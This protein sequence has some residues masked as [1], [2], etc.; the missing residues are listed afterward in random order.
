MTRRP[1]VAVLLANWNGARF[2]DEA[3]TSVVGQSFTDWVL[4]A[5][6]TGSRDDSPAIIKKW[7][8]TDARIQPVLI[9]QRLSYPEALNL[10]LARAQGDYVAR[11]ESD[12][13]WLPERL[14]R[15]IEFYSQADNSSVGVCGTDALLVNEFGRPVRLKQFPRLHV[16]CL[17][18]IWYRNP[19][20]NSSVLIR[21]A[22][23]AEIGGYD[24][25]FYMVEDL[26]LWFRLGRQWSLR[27]IPEALVRYRV[28]PDSTSSRRLAKVAWLGGK[29]RRRAARKFG[30]R[31]PGLAYA[32]NLTSVAAGVLPPLLARRVF[33]CFVGLGGRREMGKSLLKSRAQRS[34]YRSVLTGGQT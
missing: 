4:I 32:Y 18:A 15:Q 22:A 34:S 5:V 27:N 6:D 17:K 28:W 29:V 19:F 31:M 23:L 12:D 9:P 25:S 13:V 30:Y 1:V 11:I 16:D 21:M 2:I 10:G 3:I 7:A 14:Q 24:P 33:E 8:A 20:C 26:E